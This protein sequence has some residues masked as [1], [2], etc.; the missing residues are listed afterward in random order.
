MLLVV[1]HNDGFGLIRPVCHRRTPWLAAPPFALH[2]ANF[3]DAA[4][5]FA[6]LTLCATRLFPLCGSKKQLKQM[7]QRRARALCAGP[8]HLAPETNETVC[9]V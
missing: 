9:C 5:K 6:A 2:T 1:D 7:K 3:S 4:T 8:Y